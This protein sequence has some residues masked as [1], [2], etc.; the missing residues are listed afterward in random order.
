MEDYYEILGVS[1]DASQEEI[2][3]AYRKL[4]HEHHP[5]KGGDEEKFKKINKAYQVLSDEQKRAQYDKY[6]EVPGGGA[7]AGGRAG[8]GRGFGQD[9]NQ[10]QFNFGNLEDILS[11][12]FGGGFRTRTEKKTAQGQ[13]IK[14]DVRI[15]LEEILEDQKK[16]ISLNKYI[17][18][19]RCE[20][21]GA[22]SDSEMEKCST[23][24]GEGKV[25]QVKQ[26]PF[27]SI[28]KVGICPDCEGSGS[29]PEEECEKC[30]GVG[31]IKKQQD[32]EFT[33]PAGVS[34]EQ[35]LRFEGQGHAA[36]KGGKAGDLYVRIAV[37]NKSGFERKGDDLYTT[38]KISISQAVLGDEVEVQTLKGNAKLQIPKGSEEGD[39]LK[40]KGKGIPKFSGFG[41]GDLYVKLGI[42]IPDD[43]T[44]EQEKLMKELKKKGL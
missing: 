25:K 24:D 10:E 12:M 38:R 41:R 6:G 4:A 31:R 44:S 35:V 18:C 8:F 7:G 14:V 33:I 19:P 5:D 29:V 22:E 32:F 37:N 17:Q 13:D 43:L 40:I 3:K 27:G 36:K 34:S 9:F 30:H 23:C 1:R 20:G 11:Q 2:K 15:D 42:N 21:T 26:S 39:T 28:T 16:S